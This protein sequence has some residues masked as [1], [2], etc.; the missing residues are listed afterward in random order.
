[1]NADDY[2]QML[3]SR[4]PEG[5]CWPSADDTD[6]DSDWDPLLSAMSQEPAR[7]DAD[8]QAVIEKVIPDNAD[9]DLLEWEKVVG[10]PD[11]NLTDEERLAR[12]VAILRNRGELDRATLEAVIQKRADD[13]GVKLYNRAYPE[14]Q[15]FGNTVCG[16]GFGGHALQPFLWLCELWPNLNPH[17]L[18]SVADAAAWI[19]FGSHTANSHTSPVTLANTAMAVSFTGAFP[20]GRTVAGTADGDT[21]YVS[22]WIWF[23]DAEVLTL[24]I[25]DRDGN[26]ALSEALELTPDCWHKVSVQAA[27]GAGA[28]TPVIGLSTASAAN[29]RMSWFVYGVRNKTLENFV[30]ALMPMHTRGKFGVQGEY[31]TILSNDPEEVYI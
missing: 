10:S 1:M 17:A 6:E 30:T 28:T 8:A 13:L 14:D 27:L 11:T 18:D 31:E 4:L 2:A 15:G 25:T 21:L 5:E 20:R 29:A 26:T 19:G 7:I 9:T 24:T 12:I 16:G 22:F 3:K 23:D